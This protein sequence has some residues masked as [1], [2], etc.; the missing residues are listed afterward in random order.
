M[1]K[2]DEGYRCEVCGRDVEA[3]TESDLYLRY[4]LG[5]VPLE[6]IHRLPERHIACNPALAQYIMDPAFPCVVCE[7]AFGKAHL[8]RAYVCEEED[9]VTRGWRRLQAIP[10]LGLAVPEYP[11]SVTPEGSNR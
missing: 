10:T 8:D 11:F 5:E 9:R 3:I 6:M 2:C 4:V 7:G 1:A